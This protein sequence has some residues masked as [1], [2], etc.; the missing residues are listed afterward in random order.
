[1]VANVNVEHYYPGQTIP[2]G[3]LS[4]GDG[5]TAT[6]NNRFV[7]DLPKLAPNDSWLPWYV[8]NEP[9]GDYYRPT[10]Q[11]NGAWHV[12]F[13]ITGEGKAVDFFLQAQHQGCV[14]TI[15]K[16]TG[17]GT[18]AFQKWEDPAHPT[19]TTYYRDE[20]GGGNN[21]LPWVFYASG[22][23]FYPDNPDEGESLS[24][25]AALRVTLEAN[26]TYYIE[27]GSSSTDNRLGA[28]DLGYFQN[29]RF[30]VKYTDMPTN[31]LRANAKTVNIGA[32]GTYNDIVMNE[33]FGQSFTP[34]DDPTPDYYY[35]RQYRTAWWKYTPK[36]SGQVTASFALTPETLAG[37]AFSLVMWQRIE[38]GQLVERARVENNPGSLTYD[39]DADKDYYFSIGF[40]NDPQYVQG[41]QQYQISVH[42][43]KA[44]DTIGTE[45]APPGNDKRAN[46]W[47]IPTTGGVTA[48]SDIT[49]ATKD[50][51]DYG[52]P[53]ALKY[54]QS[55]W[56]KWTCT[57]GGQAEVDLRSSLYS[58]DEM[59]WMQIIDASDNDN[60]VIQRSIVD[61]PLRFKV[62]KGHTYFFCVGV[63]QHSSL[64]KLNNVW[65]ALT[66][67][68]P[69]A[70]PTKPG[71]KKPNPKTPVKP[72][73]P[74][75]STI[76]DLVREYQKASG[77][78]VWFI[79]ATKIAVFDPFD[80]P[81]PANFDEDLGTYY[82]PTV[83]ATSAAKSKVLRLDAGSTDMTARADLET[84]DIGI[85]TGDWK[86]PMP[87]PF[88][89]T[90]APPVTRITMSFTAEGFRAS[91]EFMF[92]DEPLRIKA[93][94]IGSTQYD[95]E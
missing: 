84:N 32:S 56:W 67:D 41:G 24:T 50:T 38:L 33:G 54:E 4:S 82:Y 1:M 46:A 87:L 91:A 6:W 55:V 63:V 45:G 27:I 74:A 83:E 25:Y 59:L 12:L 69:I 89:D 47:I 23:P 68:P 19:N 17:I 28:G 65:V 30:N 81:T 16:R 85:V 90:Y 37:T 35:N 88:P 13:N 29:F 86:L 3:E 80:L 10:A 22:T 64:P 52:D 73:P 79:N 26:E 66:L 95:D 49:Y 40:R 11:R 77:H 7:Y 34:E 48:N 93:T 78:G 92:T 9:G 36:E 43:P 71:T 21:G 57:Y 94:E 62:V 20:W 2:L 14:M 39:V 61:S 58:S 31:D 8:Y 72:K 76:L 18:Q 53:W 44:G 5:W 75:C 60:L 42:G 15:W 51:G 70:L